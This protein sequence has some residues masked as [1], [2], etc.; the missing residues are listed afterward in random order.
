MCLSEAQQ[1]SLR[2]NPVVHVLL[3]D[4]GGRGNRHRNPDTSGEILHRDVESV[5]VRSVRRLDSG[6]G[7]FNH[8]PSTEGGVISLYIRPEYYSHA[9]QI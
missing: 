9:S 1:L 3:D 4:R 8:T 2:R 6:Y 7:I 5:A